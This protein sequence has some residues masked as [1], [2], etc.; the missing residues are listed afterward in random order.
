MNNFLK[1]LIVELKN[2]TIFA[3]TFESFFKKF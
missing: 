1:K 3:A 2:Y